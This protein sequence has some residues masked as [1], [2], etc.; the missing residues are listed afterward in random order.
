M[1]GAQTPRRDIARD[2]RPDSPRAPPIPLPCRVK[3]LVF[4]SVGTR[5]HNSKHGAKSPTK[6][7]EP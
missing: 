2:A 3:S 7:N 4:T 6:L 1:R 5:A